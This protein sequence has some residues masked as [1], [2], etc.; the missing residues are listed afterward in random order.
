[1]NRVFVGMD[2]HKEKIVAVGL[3]EEGNHPVMRE[4]FGGNDL[5]RLVKRLRQLAKSHRVE[6]CY[7]AGPCGYGLTRTL[8]QAGVECRVAA[9]SLIPRR[10]GDRIKTDGR[11]AREL[12]LAFRANTLSFVRIPSREEEEV[13]GLIRCREDIAKEVRRIKHVIAHWLR[14]E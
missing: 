8:L 13:R 7:E 11:D 14:C 3:P 10:P 5:S 9:P 1:M 6:A 4:E 2:V 12:A